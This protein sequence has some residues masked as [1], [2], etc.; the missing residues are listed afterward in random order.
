MFK[1][2]NAKKQDDVNKIV[3]VFLLLTLS[4]FH[5]FSSVFIVDFEQ[6]NVSRQL[7]RHFTPISGVFLVDFEQVNVYWVN[8]KGPNEYFTFWFSY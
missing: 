2:N 3:L 8:T 1:A 5:T 4:I 6:V 7:W